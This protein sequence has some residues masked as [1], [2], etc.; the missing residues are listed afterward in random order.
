MERNVTFILEALVRNDNWYFYS[1]KLLL[2]KNSVNAFVYVCNKFQS[3]IK[4]V[5]EIIH[6]CLLTSSKQSIPCVSEQEEL[7][8]FVMV[9]NLVIINA[10]PY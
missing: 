1:H 6:Y 8:A 2:V 5:Y 10:H 3:N 4:R 9:K 7:I